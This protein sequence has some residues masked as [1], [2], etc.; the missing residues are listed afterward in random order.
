MLI[1]IHLILYIFIHSLQSISKNV[2]GIENSSNNNLKHIESIYDKDEKPL[3]IKRT[4]RYPNYGGFGDPG[5][6]GGSAGG[7]YAPC[8]AVKA[9]KSCRRDYCTYGECVCVPCRRRYIWRDRFRNHRP[10]PA[11]RNR[12]IRRHW[13]LRRYVVIEY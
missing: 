6:D 1:F 10:K 2:Y 9:R 12:K 5:G 4:K 8:N 7:G 11:R 3:T 13:W